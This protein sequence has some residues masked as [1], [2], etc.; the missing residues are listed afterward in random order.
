[1]DDGWVGGLWSDCDS[2]MAQRTH[3]RHTQSAPLGFGC[4]TLMVRTHDNINMHTI[5]NNTM[6]SMIHDTVIQS[7]EYSRN[8]DARTRTC[9]CKVM[10]QKQIIHVHV[11]SVKQQHA[12]SGYDIHV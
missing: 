4:A 9:K 8:D 3:A 1:M 5:Y 10:I 11:K 12:T 7:T 6:M 2:P